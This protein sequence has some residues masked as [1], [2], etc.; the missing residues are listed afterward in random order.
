[1]RLLGFV[2]SSYFYPDVSYA[3]AVDLDLDSCQIGGA[4]LFGYIRR[5]KFFDIIDMTKSPLFY[6]SIER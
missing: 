4:H 6:P 1:M 5:V 2:V 3:H